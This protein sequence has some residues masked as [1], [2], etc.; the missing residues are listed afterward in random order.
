MSQESQYI[1]Y[2]SV[3]KLGEGP[4]LVL[5]PH[6]DDEVFGC[7]GAILAH[8]A[9]ADWV[10]VVVVTDGQH[11][12]G[13]STD[14]AHESREAAQ[15]LDVSQ[16][17]F[18][19]LPDRELVADEELIARLLTIMDGMDA[20][21]VYAPSLAEIHPDHRALAQ[22]AIEAVRRRSGVTLAL[23]EVSAP[24]S[25]NCLLD[26]T[27]YVDQKLAA[28]Q[29][30]TSQLEGHRYDAYVSGLNRF[31][32]MTLPQTVTAAEAFWLIKSEDLQHADPIQVQYPVDQR[33]VPRDQALATPNQSHNSMTVDE[34]IGH[35]LARLNTLWGEAHHQS[36]ETKGSLALLKAEHAQIREQ[37]DA[38][39]KSRTWRWSKPLRAL[40][41]RK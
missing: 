25:P 10:Q 7:A 4:V 37:L 18:W 16:I 38:I 23:Y 20:R 5:A 39:E 8:R 33:L 26:I 30:F 6:P 12:D 15:L 14:R 19:S 41:G 29:C 1:P 9:H 2:E 3:T 21:L 27:P 34:E 24:V 31:R 35:L 40:L 28:M 36:D 22:A 13:T 32:A 17:E 11:G